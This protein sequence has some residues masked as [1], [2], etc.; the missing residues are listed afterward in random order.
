M[1]FAWSKTIKNIW[2]WWKSTFF[3]ICTRGSCKTHEEKQR[4]KFVGQRLGV[5]PK[6]WLTPKSWLL[7]WYF[8]L[9]TFLHATYMSLSC[10]FKCFFYNFQPCKP[11]RKHAFAGRN[12]QHALTLQLFACRKKNYKWG[13]CSGATLPFQSHH[14]TLTLFTPLHHPTLTMSR[15]TNIKH[16]CHATSLVCMLCL[17]HLWCY[18]LCTI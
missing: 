8:F 9:I 16:V 7:I 4:K 3:I 15:Q 17:R 18:K 6:S 5:S 13:K 14:P 1:Y 11:M 2:K 12:T 10:T